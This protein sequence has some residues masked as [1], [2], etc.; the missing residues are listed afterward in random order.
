MD[1]WLSSERNY[2]VVF[3]FRSAAL[4]NFY[5]EQSLCPRQLA[6]GLPKLWGITL[7]RSKLWNF[8]LPFLNSNIF[9]YQ[10][11]TF[12]TELLWGTLLWIITGSV[13]QR[14]NLKKDLSFSWKNG[15][16]S[17]YP[18]FAKKQRYFI[19]PPDTDN[20]W[21]DCALICGVQCQKTKE[22]SGCYFGKLELS[23]FPILAYS[24]SRRTMR[25]LKG[26]R[27]L[28]DP[29]LTFSQRQLSDL[30]RRGRR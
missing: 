7:T 26:S 14:E 16:I 28:L 5:K 30:R 24:S 18:V 10:H 11:L 21:S 9:N 1:D 12:C 6:R 22:Y 4:P 8:I 20:D 27:G 19:G 15:C 2:I 25:T 3:V 13:E 29:S 17:T 23:F